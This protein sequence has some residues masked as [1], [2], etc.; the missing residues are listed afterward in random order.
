[1]KEANEAVIMTLR[2]LPYTQHI[3]AESNDQE[4][5]FGS[6]IGGGRML[7]ISFRR[8]DYPH[9]RQLQLGARTASMLIT[10]FIYN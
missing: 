8:L 9:T 1:M 3:L 4:T 5:W 6:R 10:R 7:E 2:L